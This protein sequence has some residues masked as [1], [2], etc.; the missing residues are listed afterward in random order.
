MEKENLVLILDHIIPNNSFA[1]PKSVIKS[2]FNYLCKVFYLKMFYLLRFLG[3]GGSDYLII[4][5]LWP[6]QYFL[7]YSTQTDDIWARAK[8]FLPDSMCA[9]QR[10]RSAWASICLQAVECLPIHH[11]SADYISF[12]LGSFRPILVYLKMEF[13]AESHSSP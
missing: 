1:I 4:Y 13:C 10:L 8:H 2:V 5:F 9:K 3:I 11:H 6:N 7:A 12:P